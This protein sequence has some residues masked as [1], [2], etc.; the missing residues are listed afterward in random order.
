MTCSKSRNKFTL[1]KIDASIDLNSVK[2]N[3]ETKE[4]RLFMDMSLDL[5][6]N[7]AD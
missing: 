1:R 2:K 5:D 7:K 6:I 3:Q 4:S